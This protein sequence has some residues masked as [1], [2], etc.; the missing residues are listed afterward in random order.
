MV[1]VTAAWGACFVA[2]G[3]GLRDAPVLWF[4]A[5]RAL[6]AGG[7]L[8]LLGGAQHRPMPRS[9]RSWA[10]IA[11]LGL[12]NVTLALGAMFAGAAG[13]AKGTAAVLA[14]AQPLL[15]LLP[16]WWLYRERPTRSTTVALFLGLVGL[17][18]VASAAG[19]GA[20]AGLSLGAAAATTTGTL[21]FRRLGGVDVMVASGWHLII[22]GTALAAWAAATEGAPQIAWTARFVF[23]LAFLGLVGTAATSVAWFTEVRHARLDQLA[24]W[25]LLV[26]VVGLGLAAVVVGERPSGRMSVGLAVV[27]VAM[28]IAQRPGGMSRRSPADRPDAAPTLQGEASALGAGPARDTCAGAAQKAAA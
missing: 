3:W 15:I 25:T 9:R 17:A 12:V 7:A 11:L 20:G 27:L 1:W 4:A 18:V 2:I 19:G 10:L 24:A 8:V 22:G 28:W 23:S 26:P 16:A 6:V 21:L 5:L 14:N 13:G